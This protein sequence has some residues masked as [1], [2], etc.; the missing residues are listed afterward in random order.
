MI[1]PI[2]FNFCSPLFEEIS[3]DDQL[4]ED[5]CHQEKVLFVNIFWKVKYSNKASL[6]TFLLNFYLPK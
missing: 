6:F 4:G 2:F 5:V 3:K 1:I